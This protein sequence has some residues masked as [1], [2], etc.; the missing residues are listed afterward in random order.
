MN[1]QNRAFR[2]CVLAFSVLGSGGAA[3]WIVPGAVNRT[4]YTGTHYATDVWILN[5]GNTTANVTLQLIPS[6]GSTAPAPVSQTIAPGATLAVRNAIASLWSMAEASGAL[7]IDGDQALLIT[8]RAYTD[9]NPAGAFAY[10][11][12]SLPYDQTAVAGDVLHSVWAS[13]SADPAQG[14]RGVAGAILL[15]PTSAV[16]VVVFDS[17]GAELARK[18]VTG[19]P[20]V[21]E[22]A[23]GDLAAADLPIARVEFDI[24]SGRTA[25]YVVE[26]GAISGDGFYVPATAAPLSPLSS[27]IAGASSLPGSHTDIRVFNPSVQAAALQLTAVASNG[28]GLASPAQAIAIAPGQVQEI[29]DVLRSQFQAPDGTIAALQAQSTSPLLVLSRTIAGAVGAL[30]EDALAGAQLG[31]GQTGTLIG[32]QQ[33]AGAPGAITTVELTSGSDGASLNAALSDA[34]GNPVA[35]TSS[36]IVLG[37]STLQDITLDA[38][39]PGTAI[40]PDARLDLQVLSGSALATARITDIGTG[41]WTNSLASRPAE[42]SC[43]AAAVVD[44]SANPSTLAGAGPVQISW[45]TAYADS[46][47]I[48]GVSIPDLSGSVSMNLTS[49]Q[50]FTLAASGPCGKATQ[51]RSALPH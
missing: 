39:F 48:T 22:F 31:P 33:D 24:I 17:S 25:G 45:E 43:S 42:Y 23:L 50:T 20:A 12:D 13:N 18:R 28:A 11:I 49:T 30:Q 9:A 27:L 46:V 7:R 51:T 2:A 5:Q 6:M 14:L 35:A 16:D 15:A 8:A 19:G 41:D 44:F 38:L 34:G 36:P 10:Q 32:L 3:T 37:A 21:Q 40:P 47:Q 26:T 29:D 1:R 4:N